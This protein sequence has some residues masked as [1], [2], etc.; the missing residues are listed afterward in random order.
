M[1]DVLIKGEL[2]CWH[3]NYDHEVELYFSI[4]ILLLEHLKY[5]SFGIPVDR[6][7]TF[8][9][10]QQIVTAARWDSNKTTL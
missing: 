1:K 4:V 5:A 7:L 10:A 2:D 3:M 6:L 8:P 9:A